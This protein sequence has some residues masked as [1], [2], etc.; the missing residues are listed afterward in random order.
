MKNR[1]HHEL[2][3]RFLRCQQ[4]L[5]ELQTQREGDEPDRMG[6]NS[7]HC[8]RCGHDFPIEEGMVFFGISNRQAQARFEEAEAERRW[9]FEMHTPDDHYEFAETSSRMGED[10][11]RQLARLLPPH[12]RWVLDVGAGSGYQSWQLAKHGYGVIASE[13]GVE[14]LGTA[15]ALFQPGVA[16]ERVITDCS[17]LPFESRSFDAVFCKELAHHLEDL[18]G[19]LSEFARVLKPKG[20]LMLLE[21][22]CAQRPSRS[23]EVDPAVAA[24][25][26]HHEYSLCDY[27]DAL[28]HA[29]FSMLCCRSFRKPI[30][31]NKHP[32]LSLIDRTLIKV[33]G[34]ASWGGWPWLKRRRAHLLGGSVALLAQKGDRPVAGAVASREI[35]P[36]TTKRLE[37]LQDLIGEARGAAPRF[38][39]LLQAIHVEDQAHLDRR[40]GAC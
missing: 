15:D 34:L 39:R 9:N 23:A 14:Y 29:D 16:F 17:L 28:E 1:M 2:V 30:N 32:L 25:L 33:F 6:T 4:C 10:A 38:L 26:S 31:P 37:D 27:L 20:F 36:L 18:P 22:C 35:K 19:L 3:A 21:P 11:V 12:D 7:L 24:G 40:I 13:L 8:E 5:G